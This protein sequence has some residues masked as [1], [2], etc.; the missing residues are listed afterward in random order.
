M[1]IV[2]IRLPVKNELNRLNDG[3]IP[4]MKS[5]RYS[6][7]YEKNIFK[8]TT[9]RISFKISGEKTSRMSTL[10]DKTSSLSLKIK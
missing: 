8:I 6:I 2:A 9:K 1:K 3:T 4:K 10:I 7:P 5:E